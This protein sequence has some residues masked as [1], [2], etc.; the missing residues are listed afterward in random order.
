MCLDFE[1]SGNCSQVGPEY[2]LV[3]GLGAV[4][5]TLPVVSFPQENLIIGPP[6]K[7]E[8]TRVELVP[9]I[10]VK[11]GTDTFGSFGNPCNHYD[12]TS[13]KGIIHI[14]EKFAVLFVDC[15]QPLHGFHVGFDEFF[16]GCQTFCLGLFH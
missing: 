13:K 16:D 1:C 3:H 2:C 12:F 14:D 10:T 6:F 11:A 8:H 7:T 5:G 9:G 15:S 4:F